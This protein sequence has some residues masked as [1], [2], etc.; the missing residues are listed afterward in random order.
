MVIHEKASRNQANKTGKEQAENLRSKN[1]LVLHKET[2]MNNVRKQVHRVT[3]TVWPGRHGGPGLYTHT[4]RQDTGET[5][6]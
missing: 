2:N 1:K 3:K 6:R 5:N 4:G